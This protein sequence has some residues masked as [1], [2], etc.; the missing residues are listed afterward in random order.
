MYN[1]AQQADVLFLADMGE[2]LR[3]DPSTAA[4]P[5][6][7]IQNLFWWSW[8]PNSGDT[9][10]VV[11]ND[12]LT[13]RLSNHLCGT[14][15]PHKRQNVKVLM[16][17]LWMSRRILQAGKLFLSASCHATVHLIPDCRCVAA[18]GVSD[19]GIWPAALLHG[20]SGHIGCL[21]PICCPLPLHLMLISFDIWHAK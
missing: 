7:P 12:W 1:A 2:Y 14:L 5:H 18:V 19:G 4:Y 10:G 6:A 20:Q 3:N 9:G 17:P 21:L 15:C 8:N 13:V 16:I 11:Q